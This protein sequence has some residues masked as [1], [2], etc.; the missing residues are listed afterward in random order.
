MA[1]GRG[2][3]VPS[4]GG[5]LEPFLC[6]VDTGANARDGR[7]ASGNGELHTGEELHL[8]IPLIGEDLKTLW[9]CIGR[10]HNQ[11]AL[12]SAEYI[13]TEGRGLIGGHF[14]TNHLFGGH[15]SDCA[16]RCLVPSITCLSQTIDGVV[17]Q[18]IFECK[19]FCIS[20]RR[21]FPVLG[22]LV[23]HTFGSHAQ[24]S[25]LRGNHV[26]WVYAFTSLVWLRSSALAGGAR[27]NIG[28]N[29]GTGRRKKCPALI[30]EFKDKSDPH[31]RVQGLGI[32]QPC[33]RLTERA[34][35]GPNVFYGCSGESASRDPLLST[36]Q[37]FSP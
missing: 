27:R 23:L 14:E 1:L 28:S 4:I 10:T 2:V 15:L 16:R 35:C 34:A 8:Y 24:Q 17:P 20:R 31:W 32:E 37:G 19:R 13:R 30:G 3:D 29:L 18:A 11:C 25:E 9:F 22:T 7:R 21:A 33:W 6:S 36:V 5:R 12:A 26:F